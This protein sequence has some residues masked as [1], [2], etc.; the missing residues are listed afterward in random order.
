MYENVWQTGYTESMSFQNNHQSCISQA[1]SK[2]CLIISSTTPLQFSKLML[3]KNE[4][5]PNN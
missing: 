2:F 3:A 4:K 5:E 1:Q